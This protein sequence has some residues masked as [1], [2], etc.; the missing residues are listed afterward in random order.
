M[1]LKKT[2]M[3]F[4]LFFLIGLVTTTSSCTTLSKEECQSMNWFAQGKSD[5]MRGQSAKEFAKYHKAC[6]KHSISVD[7][8]AYVNGR[9]RGLQTFCTYESGHQEGLDGKEY[10][11]V[12]PKDLEADFLKGFR[13]GKREYELRQKEEA[14]AQRKRELD[15]Q[16]AQLKAKKSLIFRNGSKTCS[17]NSDCRTD[18]FCSSGACI[19]SGKSCTFNSDCE[20]E[21]Y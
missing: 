6:S 13:L 2:Y 16:E 19:G 12:C 1:T 11:G 9:V 20:I 7:L 4:R 14:I 17:F 5:G 18:G 3:L 21:T 10:F 15:E 8:E